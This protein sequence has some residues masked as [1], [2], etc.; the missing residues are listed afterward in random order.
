LGL[1][2]EDLYVGLGVERYAGLVVGRY[3]GVD[4]V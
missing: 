3:A 1:G 2:V 4:V